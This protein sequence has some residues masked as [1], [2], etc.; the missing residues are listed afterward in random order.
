MKF[1]RPLAD[2]SDRF[3]IWI[4]ELG[5]CF[6]QVPRGM[7]LEIFPYSEAELFV[8]EVRLINFPIRILPTIKNKDF[9]AVPCNLFYLTP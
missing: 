5:I 4:L 7:K 6:W 9:K 1:I 2:G 8:K 3:G